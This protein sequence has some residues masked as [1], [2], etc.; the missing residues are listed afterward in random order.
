MPSHDH[1]SVFG[2]SNRRSDQRDLSFHKY[3]KD[4]DLRARWVQACKREEGA[5]FTISSSTVV[6]SEHFREKDFHP[7][8]PGLPALA[9]GKPHRRLKQE[10]IPSVF[11]FRRPPAER[12]SPADRR[13]AALVRHS[14]LERLDVEPKAKKP[15]RGESESEFEYRVALEAAETEIQNLSTSNTANT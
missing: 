11:S 7:D 15:R 1:C 3:P 6:C 10:S 2:C 13:S 14:L 12:P 4:P 9:S 5:H 8:L